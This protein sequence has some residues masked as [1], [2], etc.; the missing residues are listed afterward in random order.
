MVATVGPVAPS[1]MSCA[2]SSRKRRRSDFVVREY[3]AKSAPLTASGMF[4]SAK[5]GPSRLEKNGAS[6][7]RS[8]SVN[9]S[10][11]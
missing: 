8:V 4:V 10:S 1:T 9:A 3:R 2:N 7:D 11:T 5:T 6:V